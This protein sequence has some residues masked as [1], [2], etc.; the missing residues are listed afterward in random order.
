M[1]RAQQWSVDV[2]ASS[3]LFFTFSDR[4]KR[5]RVSFKDE[6][7][8]VPALSVIVLRELVRLLKSPLDLKFLGFAILLSFV[9]Q[10]YFGSFLGDV[11]ISVWIN[12]SFSNYLYKNCIG[13][14]FKL[15]LS[16]KNDQSNPLKKRRSVE[17]A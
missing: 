1:Y 16:T 8:Y 6:T 3:G 12:V 4:E 10:I 9:M 2:K 11:R 5:G 13:K 7:F 14:R 15:K 17:K